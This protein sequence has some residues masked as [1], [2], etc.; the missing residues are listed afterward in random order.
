MSHEIE[1][2]S[3]RK[4]LIIGGLAMLILVGGFGGWAVATSIS[5]AVIASAQIEVDQNR[6]IVQHPDGGVVEDVVVEEGDSV[7]AGDVLISLD[8]VSL[9]SE[10]SIVEGQMFELLARGGRVR[11]ER[12][13]AETVEF[14]EELLA[15]AHREEVADLIKGQRNLFQAR[16]E[17]L[18]K[19][20][21]QLGRRS[22]Q[23]QS[24]VVG[25]DAQREALARQ[26]ELIDLELEDQQQLLDRG[27][28]QA[29][30]V[31]ALE[32]EKARLEGQIGELTANRAESE[33]RA[34]E[35]EIEIL[36]LDTSRR[37]EAI[38]RLRDLEFNRLEL[39]ERRRSLK[40]RMDRLDIRAPVS[41][42]V[43]GMT[44]NTPRAVIRP[45]DPV[46]YIVP[47]D[48]PFVIAAR[49]DPI[50]VDQVFVGQ[51]TVL[52]FSAFDMRTTPELFG[53]VTQV[54]ADAFVDERTQIS[55]YRA[56]IML[57]EGELEKLEGLTVIPGMPVEAFIRTN[58]RTPM[59]YLTKP[60]TDY[61]TRA[62]KDG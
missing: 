18:E 54:S 49:V 19:E 34:T 7:E 20:V 40:E 11:A 32:R 14:D 61:L 4:P 24:Q 42:V 8:Q 62:F 16:L 28:A 39:V 1:P 43:Y 56:E 48:R 17:S 37:E 57:Q 45:A 41:G 21:E 53:R 12:D 36:K 26:L 23:I 44:V 13:N 60:F 3:A 27:L 33:G 30:R 38:T 51:E 55:Y 52:R 2:P 15:Q 10:M 22:E 25:I 29:S 35:I 47:Q 58:D 59:A 46:L 5:G 6:Q 31:L 50:H 9:A